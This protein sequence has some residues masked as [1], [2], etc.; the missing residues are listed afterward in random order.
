MYKYLTLI[1]LFTFTPCYSTT[2]LIPQ[3]VQETIN[4]LNYIREENQLAADKLEDLRL[5]T[6]DAFELRSI[7]KI[8][9]ILLQYGIYLAERIKF[10]EEHYLSL[11]KEN[12]AVTLSQETA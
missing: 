10:F 12:K 1:L 11:M 7:S 3:N 9:D 4:A 6:N 2:P 5:Q 8:I